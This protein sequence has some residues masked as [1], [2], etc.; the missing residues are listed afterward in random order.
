MKIKG[1]GSVRLE[2]VKARPENDI[3]S[4]I[5]TEGNFSEVTLGK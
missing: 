1:Q 5:K 2:S 3:G 4:R